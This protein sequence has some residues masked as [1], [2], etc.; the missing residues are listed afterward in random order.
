MIVVW[1]GVCAVQRAAVVVVA[2]SSDRDTDSDLGGGVMV[3]VG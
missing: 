3:L 2:L 1:S